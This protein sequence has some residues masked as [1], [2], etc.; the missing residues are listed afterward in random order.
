MKLTV[1]LKKIKG[2]FTPYTREPKSGQLCPI[3][4][5]N[6]NNQLCWRTYKTTAEAAENLNATI[7]EL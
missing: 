1:Y 6:K 4:G 5:F 7:V 3:R 2:K